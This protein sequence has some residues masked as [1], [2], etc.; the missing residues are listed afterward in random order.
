[1]GA[2]ARGAGGGAGGAAAAGTLRVRARDE[3]ERD[4]AGGDDDRIPRATHG[5]FF[6]A[7]SSL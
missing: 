6:L 4:H 2:A 5:S 1:M 7:A 3:T